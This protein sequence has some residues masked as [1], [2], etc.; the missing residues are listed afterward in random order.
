MD[1]KVLPWVR[2]I[3]TLIP[4]LDVL[5]NY[6]AEVGRYHYGDGQLHGNGDGT[7]RYRGR[8]HSRGD[9][10]GNPAIHRT[11]MGDGSSLVN[12]DGDGTVIRK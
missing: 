3:H 4:V 8:L 9:G 7:D 2:I 12:E 5:R 11:A 10:R 1:A 6:E